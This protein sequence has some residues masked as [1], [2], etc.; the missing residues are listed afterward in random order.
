[1]Q[2]VT[3]AIRIKEFRRSIGF[4][5]LFGLLSFLLMVVPGLQAQSGGQRDCDSNA[6]IRCGA[7]TTSEMKRKYN[8][9]SDVRGIFSHMGINRGDMANSNWRRGHVASDGKVVVDGKT[10]ATNA[11]TAGRQNMTGSRAVTKNGT[12][13]YVRSPGVSFGQG[14]LDALVAMKNGRFQHAVLTSCGNPVKAKPVPKPVA[15]QKPEKPQKKKVVVKKKVVQKQQQTQSQNIVV[16]A[17]PAPPAPPEKEVPQPAPVPVPEAPAAPAEAPAP[18]G[19][20]EVPEALPD[21]GPGQALGVSALVTLGG[22]V[23]YAIY[24]QLRS[25]FF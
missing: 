1:M 20:A 6:V 11:M 24:A 15:K 3:S 25:R 2:A 16:Q 14:Q 13:F 18:A 12:T 9:Q 4:G 23:W 7:L 8:S 5:V 17:P 10:V 19:K 22:T 21:T